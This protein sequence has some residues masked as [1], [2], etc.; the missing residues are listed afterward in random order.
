MKTKMLGAAFV[1]SL[2]TLAVRSGHA[3][4]PAGHGVGDPARSTRGGA[5]ESVTTPTHFPSVAHVFD[6][7]PLACT[8]MV[9]TAIAELSL[10]PG[11]AAFAGTCPGPRHQSGS[12]RSYR[13]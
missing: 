1:I 7:G 6:A 9:I 4:F 10:S 8:A 3:P 2:V 5:E 13:R 12:A 11:L